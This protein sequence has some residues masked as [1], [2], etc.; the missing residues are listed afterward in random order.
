M[1]RE[2]NDDEFEVPETR[3]I[4][5]LDDWLRQNA[6]GAP[7]P[8]TNLRQ[9]EERA[10]LK[11]FSDYQSSVHDRIFADKEK[12]EKT[13]C[14][15]RLKQLEAWKH[16]SVDIETSGS[17]IADVKLKELAES[18]DTVYALASSWNFYSSD[19]EEKMRV[20]LENYSEKSVR[21]FLSLLDN[22]TEIE[23]LSGEAIV[24]CCQ[25]AHYL[26][27]AAILQKTTAI[28]L[29]SI[30]SENCLSICQ[31]ADQLNLDELF[32]RSVRHMIKSLMGIVEGD[33]SQ[34]EAWG[35]LTPELQQRILAIKGALQS[36]VHDGSRNCLYFSSLT[37]YISIFAERVQ[38]CRERLAEARE[39]HEQMIPRTKNWFDTLTKIER[40]ENRVRTLEAVLAE[41]KKLFSGQG[42]VR[43]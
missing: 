13:R 28:L 11:E 25:M 6:L 24:D 35:H 14:Q 20:S 32:E 27:N 39:Q 38:Y 19:R 37:E 1:N 42:F 2:N 16:V 15:E 9:E 43:T 29:D 41:Q 10:L 22:M 18:C 34:S 30:D 17:A 26:Q 21:T 36:S 8:D 40:Q 23:E 4:Q 5:G 31:L 12:E 7:S 33:D 3:R